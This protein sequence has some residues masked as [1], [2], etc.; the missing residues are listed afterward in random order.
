MPGVI[1]QVSPA[2]PDLRLARMYPCS[3]IIAPETECGATPASLYRRTCGVISHARNVW[4][5]PV[6]AAIA[7]CGGAMCQECAR[8]GGI[9]TARLVRLSEPV[10]MP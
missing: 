4:L 3:A 7:A 10:R 9:V 1:F 6:H 5:C 8:A 2:I